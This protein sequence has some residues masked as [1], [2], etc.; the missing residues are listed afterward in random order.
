MKPDKSKDRRVPRTD[1]KPRKKASP[2]DVEG[3]DLGV[4]T[5]EIVNMI[6]ESRERHG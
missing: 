1:D 4:T 3:V 5:G 6:R 2:L